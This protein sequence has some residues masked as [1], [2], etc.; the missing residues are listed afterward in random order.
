MGASG[1]ASG[2][3]PSRDRIKTLRARG[4][5]VD[6]SVSVGSGD[7]VCVNVDVGMKAGVE[8][9]LLFEDWHANRNKKRSGRIFFI[10]CKNKKTTTPAMPRQ[11]MNIAMPTINHRMFPLLSS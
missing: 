5:G 10:Y 2:R 1:I 3:K 11:A 6:I 4:V 9:G 8:E 7:G